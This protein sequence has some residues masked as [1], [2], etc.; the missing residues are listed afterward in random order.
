M[1]QRWAV[2]TVNSLHSLANMVSLMKASKTCLKINSF[3]L[4]IMKHLS[5]KQF[6]TLA[7]FFLVAMENW[8][9]NVNVLN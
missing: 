2:G 5:T 6:I 7:V 3:Y 9:Q 8:E 4:L 1:P